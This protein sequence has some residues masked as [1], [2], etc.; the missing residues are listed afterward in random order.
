MLL[1]LMFF[2]TLCL[3][4][5]L[6]FHVQRPV[7]NTTI[8]SSMVFELQL[9]QSEHRSSPNPTTLLTVPSIAI[10]VSLRIVN[11]AVDLDT[12]VVMKS[13]SFTCIFTNMYVGPGWNTYEISL[14][15]DNVLLQTSH[16][17]VYAQQFTENKLDHLVAMTKARIHEHFAYLILRLG[18]AKDINEEID[19]TRLVSLD[20]RRVEVITLGDD[21]GSMIEQTITRDLCRM[22]WGASFM[23]HC[24]HQLSA[25]YNIA[26]VDTSFV[27]FAALVSHFLYGF[28]PMAINE[29]SVMDS[30]SADAAGNPAAAATTGNTSSVDFSCISLLLSTYH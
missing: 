30:D 13:L 15:K 14:S 28:R 27:S 19:W 16:V 21:D 5:S 12:T 26:F 3:I 11:N 22:W 10:N 17:Q 4:Q 20:A 7:N 2:Q 25:L 23:T 6:Q 9:Y 8:G 29:C 1:F 18:T 24:Y